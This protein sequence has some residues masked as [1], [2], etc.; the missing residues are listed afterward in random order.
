MQYKLKEREYEVSRLKE[1]L[2]QREI[3]LEIKV[4]EEDKMSNVLNFAKY[5]D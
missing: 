5:E 2:T 3:L 1:M 4:N